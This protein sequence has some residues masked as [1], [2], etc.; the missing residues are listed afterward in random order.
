MVFEVIN[1]CSLIVSNLEDGCS[2]I[3]ENSCASYKFVWHGRK[4]SRK[5]NTYAIGLIASCLYI[6]FCF[7]PSFEKLLLHKMFIEGGWLYPPEI[8]TSSYVMKLKLRSFAHLLVLSLIFN[9]Q[10]RRGFNIFT[11][12]FSF[13][14][15]VR[16]LKKWKGMWF[17]LCCYFVNDLEK[18]TFVCAVAL[19]TKFGSTKIFLPKVWYPCENFA[20]NFQTFSGNIENFGFVVEMHNPLFTYV[21]PKFF[22]QLL[23]VTVPCSMRGS[24]LSLSSFRGG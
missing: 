1:F 9:I 19:D 6:I 7:N 20:R 24:K 22:F 5:F 3:L 2:F 12:I 16:K 18:I 13:I 11:A 10:T 17:A 14:L 8:L 23:L 15:Y 4:I 21:L